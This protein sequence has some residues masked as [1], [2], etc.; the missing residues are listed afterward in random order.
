MIN[1]IYS[2]TVSHLTQ[3]QATKLYKDLWQVLGDN[4][5]LYTACDDS[6]HKLSIGHISSVRLAPV[7]STLRDLGYNEVLVISRG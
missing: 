3:S 2:A 4:T 5:D 7:L 6:N 1:L